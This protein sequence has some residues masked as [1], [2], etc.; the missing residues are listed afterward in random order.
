MWGRK[1]GVEAEKKKRSVMRRG[2][3]EEEG[4][5]REEEGSVGEEER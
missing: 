1:K 2:E 4:S 5:G 3:G